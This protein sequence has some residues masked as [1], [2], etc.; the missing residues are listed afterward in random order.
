MVIRCNIFNCARKSDT[1]LYLKAGMRPEELPAA[2]RT[3]LG[4]LQQF[5]TL[6]ISENS[7][8]AQVSA[9]DVLAALNDQGYFLQMPPAERL[10]E[11]A[12][13]A[14]FIQ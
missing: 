12:P 11:Q 8:L 1:Y 9:D 4:D 2:L 7:K 10:R 3:L 6:E 14:D 5:L 13:G